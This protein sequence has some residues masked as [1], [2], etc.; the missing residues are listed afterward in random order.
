MKPGE[1]LISPDELAKRQKS[2][3]ADKMFLHSLDVMVSNT[4]V[5]AKDKLTAEEREELEK[6]KYQEKIK[7]E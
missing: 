1:K 7:S 3:F 5:V 6:R 2:F 4:Y